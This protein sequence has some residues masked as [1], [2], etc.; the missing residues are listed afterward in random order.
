MSH[1]SKIE[2]EIKDLAA[3]D[4][5]C[6]RL[7][8]ELR[9]DQHTFR[10]FG[11]AAHCDHAIGVPGAKYEIGVVR[12]GNGYALTCDYYDTNI[13]KTI[14]RQGRLLKQAYAVAKTRIAARKKG[15]TVI[16]RK[17]CKGIRLHV[18]LN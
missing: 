3:L 9:R 8:I 10:W 12:D 17:T 6:Q 5:A 11:K 2:L 1:I 13:E 14:G 15:Y 4:Q 16:E 18:R 7:G